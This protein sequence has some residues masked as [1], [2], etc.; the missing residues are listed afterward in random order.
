MTAI[1]YERN[2]ECIKALIKA[3]ANVNV[4]AEVAIERINGYTTSSD[5][6]TPLSLTADKPD[7]VALLK[8][9]GAKH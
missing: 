2:L 8:D 3:G 1:Y 7:I 5:N 6:A 9:A 4:K